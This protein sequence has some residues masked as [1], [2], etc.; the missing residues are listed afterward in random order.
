MHKKGGSSTPSSGPFGHH[1][2]HDIKQ[3]QCLVLF[4]LP[5]SCCASG[6]VSAEEVN[7]SHLRSPK[8]LGISS[9]LTLFSVKPWILQK[10]ITNDQIVTIWVS[11]FLRLCNIREG[12]LWGNTGRVSNGCG[13]HKDY[14]IK[15][16]RES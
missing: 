12:A 13:V 4:I 8:S 15:S 9:A 6:E 14:L 11:P 7:D 5:H 1:S 10:K 3:S 2:P 16:H